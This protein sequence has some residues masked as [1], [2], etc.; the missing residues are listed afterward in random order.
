MWIFLVCSLRSVFFLLFVKMAT[1]ELNKF[2]DPPSV[3]GLEVCRKNDLFLIAQHYEILVSKTQ[4]KAE[5]K[6][7]VM[8]ALIDKGVF[9]AMDADPTEADELAI[10]AAGSS[11]SRVPVG[12]WVTPVTVAGGE[13]GPPFSMPKFEPISLS[14]EASPESC[15]DWRVKIRLTRLQLEA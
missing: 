11:P 1:F 7:C 5:I 3:E 13:V 6:A 2:I 4:R 8:S 14:T 12:D 10:D 9:P 15:A